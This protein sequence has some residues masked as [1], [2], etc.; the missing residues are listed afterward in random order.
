MGGRGQCQE[1]E[2]GKEASIAFTS[3]LIHVWLDKPV[4]LSVACVRRLVNDEVMGC[5]VDKSVL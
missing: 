2:G 5:L 1:E 3:K 4:V